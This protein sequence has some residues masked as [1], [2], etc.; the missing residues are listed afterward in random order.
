MYIVQNINKSGKIFDN[1]D[2]SVL[3]IN[4]RES[5]SIVDA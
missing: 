2:R 5:P 4:V 3:H 1:G